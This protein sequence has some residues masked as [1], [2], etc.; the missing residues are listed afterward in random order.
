MRKLI[1]AGNWKMN[2]SKAMADALLGN[3]KSK[4]AADN[5][6]QVVVFPPFLY[7]EQTSKI[8]ADSTIAWGGQ[9]LSEHEQGAFTGE[10]SGKMLQEFGC[11]YVIVGH[12]ERRHIYAES[13]QLVAQKYHQA[14]TSG[15]T[16]ILCVGETKDE[17]EQ[18]ITEQVVA[19]Q[20]SAV[21]SSTQQIPGQIIVAYEPVWAIGTGL[22]ASPE[23]AQQVHYYLR[24]V[25]SQ[26]SAALAENC[27]LLYG[28]SVKA[29]NAQ[30]LLSMADIDGVLVGGASLVADEFIGIVEAA[31][32][33]VRRQHIGA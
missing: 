11:D 28:G 29:D 2:G 16:P 18:K 27:H 21:L 15:L 31:R 13:D 22:T 8:L 3:F 6:V 4:I 1:V 26:H 25:I 7:L 23:Y 24:K 30:D 5:D 9:T 33:V 32:E 17:Y 10:I 14:V 12:S 20:L 19:R